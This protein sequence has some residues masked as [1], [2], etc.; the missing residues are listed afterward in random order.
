MEIWK[1]YG[2]YQVSNHGNVKGQKGQLMK[3]STN[4]GYKQVVIHDN[5]KK[6][7]FVHRM[8][9]LVFV[10]E[11]PEGMECDHIDR[12]KENNHIDNLKW[13]TKYENMMNRSVTRTDIEE[14]DP[15]LRQNI[16]LKEINTKARRAKGIKERPVGSIRKRNGKFIGEITINKKR[17]GS[18]S[19]AT[20]DEAQAFIDDI[21]SQHI[22]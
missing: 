13:V 2:S 14:T 5:G 11:C 4:N 7:M 8:V 17:Y 19:L 22:L 21:K 18:K 15:R 9:L 12:N 20:R 1:E 16:M 3:P 6:K 10:G